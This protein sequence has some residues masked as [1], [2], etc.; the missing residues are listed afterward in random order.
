MTT[1]TT[2]DQSNI[3]NDATTTR[4]RQPGIAIV[5]MGA[6]FPGSVD[7]R[8][9]WGHIFAKSDLITDVPSTHWKVEDYFNSDPTAPDKTYAKVGGFLPKVEFD[10]LENGIPPSLLPS[11]DTAQLLAL[12]VARTTLDDATSG[13]FAS[14]EKGRIST[15]LGV[16]SGQELFGQMASRLR[17]PEWEAGMRA[18]GLDE[19]TIKR[20]CDKIGDA[21]VPWTESSFPGLLGNVV[22]GRIANRLDLGGTNAVTDAACASSFAAISMAID[23]LVLGRAD[24][25]LT[26][27]VDALNDIFMYMCFS[28]TPALSA[29]GKIRPFDVDADGTLLGEGVG[30]LTLKRLEDAERDGDHIYAVIRGVGTSSDGRSKSVYAP[31]S[32][33]QAKALARAY[34][35][36]GYGPE[37]V[38]LVEAH[39]TGTKAGDVAEMGGLKLAFEA[40]GRKDTPWCAVGTVKSQIGHTKSAAGA[41]GIMK[42]ALALSEGILPPTI[43]VTTPNPKLGLDESP[44]YINSEARPWVRASGHPRRAGVSSFGFGGSNWHITLEEY[45]GAGRRVP[46]LTPRPAELLVV[47]G[48]DAGAVTTTLARAKAD[49]ASGLPLLDVARASAKTAKASDACRLALVVKDASDATVAIERAMA[50][51]QTG[52]DPRSPSTMFGE[53][54]RDGKLALLFSGQGSQYI[55]MGKDLAMHVDS[56]RAVLDTV[57]GTVDGFAVSHVMFPPPA[58]SD[59]AKARAESRLRATEHAQPALA[60]HEA[61]LFDVLR[62]AGVAFDMVAGHSFGEIM[63]LYAANV[64]TLDDAVRI[65]RRRGQ[66]MADASDVKGAMA[67]MSASSAI[68]RQK[69]TD[70]GLTDVVIANENAPEQT[71]IAGPE[72][73]VE[74]ALAALSTAG[75]KGSRLPV[76]TAFHSPL[77]AGA[78]EKLRTFLS[79]I[80]FSP[81]SRPV[82]SNTT[83]A[84]YPTDADAMRSV[85]AEQLG[86]PVRF[87]DEVRALHAAG[88]RFFV[89]VGPSSVLTG[90]VGRILDGQ[91]HTALAT[92]TK[93]KNGFTALL[94]TFGQLFARG[95]ALD[96]AVLFERTP[97]ASTT[98]EVKKRGP[99]VAISGANVG[100]PKL[101]LPA[102]PVAQRSAVT[103]LA[104]SHAPTVSAPPAPSTVA[105]A[106]RSSPSTHA[107]PAV[108][109]MSPSMH[110]RSPSPSH[111]SQNP[112]TSPAQARAPSSSWV[113]VF[114]EGQEQTASAH[115][116]FQR[117]LADAHT[118]FLSTYERSTRDL[119]A[120]L[121]GAAP[122]THAVSAPMPTPLATSFTAPVVVQQGFTAPAPMPTTFKAP[123]AQP[124]AAP[125]ATGSL[126][127]VGTP[128]SSL[129]DV[130]GLFLDVVAEKTGYP[131]D[132]LHDDMSLEAD[133]GID[134]I[135][136]VEILSAV[137]SKAPGLPEVDALTL[138]KLSTLGAVAAALGSVST[139]APS[140]TKA[141]A[142][143]PTAPS[144]D[145]RALFLDVVAEKTG[146]PKDALHDDMSLE[147]DLGIDS[148]KRVE[149][150]SAVKSKAPGLPEVDALTLAKLSTLGAVAAALG[151][152]NTV[153]PSSTKAT[154]AAPNTP[155]LDV[156]ALFLD[157]VAEK[158]GYPKDALHDDMSLEADLGID[159]IKRVEI[160]SAVKTKAPGLPEVDALTLAKLSTLG[161]VAAALGSVSTGASSS[162][163]AAAAQTQSPALDVRSLFL[164]VVAEKTGYPKDALH[165]DMSLEADLG[166][167]SIKRVEILSAVKTK[168]PGLPEVDALTL[169]KLSTLGA[170]AAA[171]GSTGKPPA[172][173]PTSSTNAAP[174]P[175]Q[176]A[177]RA[178]IASV[179]V[180]DHPCSA[181]APLPTLAGRTIGVFGD[182][183]LR[184]SAVVDALT[185]A[186]APAEA[187]PTA[188]LN[189]H[190]GRLFALVLVDGG[191][192]VDGPRVARARL[193]RSFKAVQDALPGLKDHRGQGF[194][195]ALTPGG[196]DFGTTSL[197]VSCAP[198]FGLAGLVKTAALEVS[199]LRAKCVDVDT[200]LDPASLAT[201]VVEELRC[202]FDDL[203]IGRTKTRRTRRTLVSRGSIAVDDGGLNRPVTV[204]TGG[205]R[206]VTAECLIAWAKVA[207]PRLAIFARSPRT[208]DVSPS[209]L[210]APDDKLLPALLADA[211]ARGVTL[212]PKDARRAADLV[213]AAREVEKNIA[214]L[215]SAGAEVQYV[216]AD[217]SDAASV[218]RA[219]DSV[220]ARLGP[221]EVIVHGAGVLADRRIEDKTLD[222]VERV[223]STK[224][225]G[226]LTVLDATASDPLRAVV[227]FSSVAGRFGNVGQADYAMANEALSGIAAALAHRPGLRARSI[228]WGPWD[229]GMVTPSL[230]RHFESMGVPLIALDDGARVFVE[231]LSSG[232]PRATETVVGGP[233][234]AE[235]LAKR[236]IAAPSSPSVRIDSRLMPF[237]IDHSVKGVPVL[238]AVFALDMMVAAVE[239]T[240]GEK[241]VS[242]RD[243]RVLRGVRLAHFENGGDELDVRLS[244][245][246]N[247]I[248]AAL[249]VRG[250]SAP[251]YRA[252]LVV[253]SALPEAAP[254][255]RPTG[256][257]VPVPMSGIY[258]DGPL[259]HGKS[260]QLLENIESV[261]D[262]LV[263]QA[264][265]LAR[266]GWNAP[267]A[268]DTAA[269]DAALQLALVYATREVGGRFLPTSIRALARTLG[270]LE[271]SGR[272][273]L[274]LTPRSVESAR[275]LCDIAVLDEQGQLMMTLEGV[276]VH[277]LPDDSV[278]STVSAEA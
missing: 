118:A 241:A 145:V 16:T 234:R 109:P 222:D 26:G 148:I 137:K 181:K 32:E 257:R 132:A 237:L 262:T 39:G 51:L 249:F 68:V 9:F 48:A 158:T 172:R 74:R 206:G 278:S 30:M 4:Q 175:V 82:F 217:V 160:L 248:E 95:V 186:G 209:V 252:T 210:A 159:S 70:A 60:A 231:E 130:R 124:V 226:L 69:L 187:L 274:V 106:T 115:A 211:V 129:L 156:R 266:S 93:G 103:P 31:V 21:F 119:V 73:S 128:A 149:I 271:K 33:G 66:L 263:A 63:A 5:G 167:D 37:T 50:S 122:L 97:V 47:S 96:L 143:A 215:E 221:I 11:T 169:A 163:K 64:L 125:V 195:L 190:S 254:S 165:D 123:D 138:A 218:A 182:D 65:A 152:V 264:K 62:R 213:V 80:P 272:V 90:L 53:G 105:T 250:E 166:I 116:A 205:A 201:L 258:G 224:L 177:A 78:A 265:G 189:G 162:T 256:P 255:P 228:A 92:D 52:S 101:P 277:R 236:T 81:A 142:A 98:T 100:R 45:T 20:A 12:M 114:R 111:P 178:P 99:T 235:S 40:S 27:G 84:L 200:A 44:F 34:E 14:V 214:R 35:V 17:R 191:S 176:T 72:A 22:A 251:R 49:L 174:A 261:G 270:S 107:A 225:D 38:E 216:V 42:A 25:V 18:A 202:G 157:V 6:L 3:A 91:P 212:S 203:E 58:F 276:E 199:G 273:T 131:K 188:G 141:T 43:N 223:L 183:A 179:V 76:S 268:V 24:M 150:L 196:G 171:L 147:A 85:L 104:P 146:Y 61:A 269:L 155:S 233:I 127:P 173:T 154:A 208:P 229:G 86:K 57:D 197:D 185:A 83:G 117:A 259:F 134:S 153:A 253:D 126:P 239:N 94:A 180:E 102:A 56:A 54:P 71:V 230:R 193:V 144:L 242:V 136:R 121:S 194:I 240:T 220:R 247:V 75:V 219:L 198:L 232:A 2:N 164:D 133:L 139:V 112:S 55:D 243:L 8:A 227:L 275:V 113:E 267:F 88:A 1:K 244:R 79:D 120:K 140:S 108:N 77:V 41:A 15:I 67:A 260:F 238:P 245:N 7:V 170:V 59:E 29:K 184:V 192:P 19:D 161:A 28:K 36:A 151:S 168:A 135:K 207:R 46:K 23:E 10:A 89:E 246:S 13:T 204:A 87:V 110:T